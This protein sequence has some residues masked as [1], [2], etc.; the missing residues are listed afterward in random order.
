MSTVAVDRSDL[1]KIQDALLDAEG[2]HRLRDQMNARTHLARETRYSPLTTTLTAARE[3]VAQ[4]LSS[5]D[6]P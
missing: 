6:M 5:G 1:M 2:F 3:R 4:I